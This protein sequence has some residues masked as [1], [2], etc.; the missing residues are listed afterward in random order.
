MQAFPATIRKVRQ[1][2]R[3]QTQ[4]PQWSSTPCHYFTGDYARIG[5]LYGKL[6]LPTLIVQE[7]GYSLQAVAEASHAFTAAF[8]AAHA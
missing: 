8:R 1:I 5:E 7:G 4:F 6:S 3:A 2:C